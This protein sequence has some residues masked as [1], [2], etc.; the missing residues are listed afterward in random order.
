MNMTE[1]QTV[2]VTLER[3]RRAA[4][5]VP[6]STARFPDGGQYRIE[7]PSVESAAAAEEAIAA[8][9]EY[10][11]EVHRLS[12]G[13]GVALLRDD[14]I[15][16]FAAIGSA[17]EIE[18]CLFVGPRAPWD[19]YSASAM[20]GDGRN[21]GWRNVGV[22]SLAAALDDVRRAVEL[23]IRSILI[24][25]EGLAALI[26]QDKQ[27]GTL[28]Q[29]LVVKASALMGIANPI[30]G[31]LLA[32][33]GFDSLNIP[34]DTRI[35]DLAAFRCAT[36]AFLDLY[37]E[38]PDGL[39]GFMRYHDLGEI[40]RVAAPVYIKF[41]LRNASAPYPSGAHLEPLARAS[42]RER[43]RRAAIGLEHLAR[44]YPEAARSPRGTDHR[45]IPVSAAKGLATGV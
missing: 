33:L 41:G 10:G 15:R 45:G 20:V 39:G 4:A 12:Q 43:V 40:V 26:G 11:V 2:H 38:A 31:A 19:G 34:S 32:S 8:A 14:E 18:I 36:S 27:T 23:G 17:H 44:Q 35:D 6:T 16:E 3:L 21:V 42:A 37:I 7:I 22:P 9:A 30:G 13:S 24:A 29:D 28:P 1:A 5:E 25:D